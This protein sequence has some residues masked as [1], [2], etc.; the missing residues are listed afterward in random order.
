MAP[1]CER[2]AGSCGAGSSCCGTECCTSGQLCCDPQGPIDRF[3]VC[4]TP[5]AD[6]PT[7]PMG[8]APLCI[9]D[10]SLKR[11]VEPVDRHAVLEALSKVPVSTWS[12]R[13]DPAGVRHMGPMAQDFKAAFEL[14]DTDRAYHS[15]DAHGVTMAAIQALYD[16]SLE[17]SR[18]I[19]RLEEENELLLRRLNGVADSHK[20]SAP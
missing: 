1:P 14:G 16:I 8:C 6:Q 13:A 11:D 10:R 18:K 5:T 2:E 20:S 4:F 15:I 19:Q 7:C 9:S 3:P 17:Q 12:Y